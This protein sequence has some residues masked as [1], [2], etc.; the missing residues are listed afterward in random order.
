MIGAACGRGA[1]DPACAEGPEALRAAGIVEH[2]LR[3]RKGVSWSATLDCGKP[4]LSA[5]EAV[6]DLCPRLAEQT[7]AAIADGTLPLVLSGDHSCAVGTWAGV[8]GA[9]RSRGD[10]GLVWIDAHL[11]SHTP[12]TSHSGAIHGMPLAA[13]LGYGETSLIECG[14]AGPKLLPHN[15]CIVGVRSFE[16]EEV[17]FLSELGV[18][19]FYMDEVERRGIGSV[20]D[21]AFQ[22]VQADTAAF[23]IS[24]DLDAIDP[25]DA[26]GVGTPA[27]SGIRADALRKAMRERGNHPRLAC[28]EISEYNPA[29]DRAGITANLV[30]RLLDDLFGIGAGNDARGQAARQTAA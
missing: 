8:A 22:L 7:H 2:L 10:L 23:G 17:R 25:I 9:L 5:L 29:R 30:I 14:G 24:V 15:V 3:V 21:D 28:I 18:R 1:L 19:I 6:A 13:L 27:E 12:A 4:G 11:D 20:L 26:P 16:V